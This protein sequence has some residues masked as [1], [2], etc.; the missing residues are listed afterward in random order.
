MPWCEQKPEVAD[1][2]GTCTPC[3]LHTLPL[4]FAGLLLSDL[5]S[6][7]L[8]CFYSEPATSPGNKS[9]MLPPCWKEKDGFLFP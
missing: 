4:H 3:P 1:G 6:T 9:H 5:A 7:A 2:G 8:V